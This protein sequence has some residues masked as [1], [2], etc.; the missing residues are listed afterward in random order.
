MSKR[1]Q[2][3]DALLAV[4]QAVD[5]GLV[6]NASLAD[7]DG[8]SFATLR[9]GDSENTD[10]FFNAP[11][12]IYE[13]TYRPTLMLIVRGDDSAAADAAL[14]AK[15]DLFVAALEAVTDLSGLI[16]AIRPQP[17]DMAPRELFGAPAMKGC[18]ITIEVDYW[19]DSS[20]G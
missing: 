5:A 16:T 9:D 7:L 20:A 1:D 15:I 17:P 8:D 11:G 3:F 12:S 19:S 14:S 6:R 2:I 4:C 18:E 13:W 10:E